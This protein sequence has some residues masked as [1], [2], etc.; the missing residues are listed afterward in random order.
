MSFVFDLPALYVLGAALCFIG[1]KYELERL[2]KIT[3]GILIALTFILFSALLY[4]DIFR[5]PMCNIFEIY[6]TPIIPDMKGSEFIINWPVYPILF[7]N[8]NNS[9]Y[10]SKDNFPLFFAIVL[11]LLYPVAIFLGYATALSYS[12]KQ[13]RKLL[14]GSRSYEDVKSRTRVAK[15]PRFSVA[16]YPDGQRGINNLKEAVEAAIEGLGGM[17]PNF[18]QKGDTVLIKANICGGNPD[19]SATYTSQEVVGY[20]VDMVR[21]AGGKPFVCD[22]DMVW[23]K[24]WVQVK[25]EGWDKWAKKNNV[26]LVNLTETN[27]VYFDFGEG[28][29]FS[30]NEKP[31]QEIVSARVLDADVIINIPKMKTHFGADVTLGMKNMYGTLPEEDKAFYHQKGGVEELLYWVNH[32]F[33]PTLTI[34][35]GSEGGEAEGPLAAHSVQ[36]NTII[37]SNN[38]V[39]ADAIAAKLMGFEHPFADLKFLR[40]VKEH[41]GDANGLLSVIPKEMNY[42]AAQLIN[43]LDLPMNSKDGKWQLPIPEVAEETWSFMENLLGFPGMAT[44]FSIGADFILLDAARLPYWKIL[45]TALMEILFSP[46]FWIRKTKDSA[47]DVSRRRINLGIFVFIALVSLYFFA[48]YLPRHDDN[49]LSDFNRSLE[50]FLGFAFALILGA[51]FSRMMQTKHLVAITLSSIGVSYFVESFAPWA[52]WW[53]YLRE[54]KELSNGW[55]GLPL[56]PYYPLLAVPIFIISI[57]GLTYV[58]TPV[59]SS[60]KGRRFRLVPYAVIMTAL[61][62]FLY[63][64]GYLAPNY[65]ALKDPTRN[66]ILIYAV[67][68]ILGLY[69]NEKEGLNWNIA[70]VMVAV[71]LGFFTEY[72][73]A[74][75]GYWAYPH[76]DLPAFIG[77][78]FGGST[79]SIN[80]NLSDYID[81]MQKEGFARLPI[82]VSLSWALNTWAAC[83]LALIFGIDMSKAFV[84][85]E[86]FDCKDPRAVV[87]KGESLAEEGEYDAAIEQYEKAIYLLTCKGQD[88]N[89]GS[90]LQEIE[91]LSVEDPLAL[92]KAWYGKGTALAS[93]G[94]FANSVMAYDKAIEQYRDIYPAL[95]GIQMTEALYHKAAAK[96]N[97]AMQGFDIPE[98]NIEAE[99]EKELRNEDEKEKKEES[100]EIGEDKVMLAKE[101]LSSYDEALNACLQALNSSP[102]APGMYINILLDK[103]LTLQQLG[104]SDECFADYDKSLA[105]FKNYSSMEAKLCVYKGLA[106]IYWADVNLERELYKEAIDC[107]DKAMEL[108]SQLKVADKACIASARWGKGYAKSKQTYLKNPDDF[109]ESILEDYH[110]SLIELDTKN[111][112][113]IWSDLGDAYMDQ[114]KYQDA[115]N[116]YEKALELHSESTDLQNANLWR[117]KGDAIWKLAAHIWMG[118][119]DAHSKISESQKDISDRLK[120]E[121]E[122]FKAYKRSIEVLDR[123]PRDSDALAGKGFVLFKM[124]RYREAL[125]AYEKAVLISEPKGAGPALMP[126]I[127]SLSSAKACTGKGNVLFSMGRDIDARL[128]FDKSKKMVKDYSPALYSSAMLS[129]SEYQRQE[130][131]ASKADE[132]EKA[133]IIDPRY[134]EVWRHR[135]TY[136]SMLGL[137]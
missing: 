84:N 24:F 17:S 12:K 70:M 61:F 49:W 42:T 116:A 40:F 38:V 109:E 28:T 45:Q 91:S 43:V 30:C 77:M 21:E 58:L 90:G 11:F 53:V 25:A 16:R 32:A 129:G 121:D 95:S 126:L 73:G 56:P 34:I 64:E 67:L 123:F 119:G 104:R 136:L 41:M 65:D 69:F 113:F 78:A 80:L 86:I 87:R 89:E 72:F 82:F 46:R 96:Q 83:G 20:V 75:S 26:E 10:I 114:I 5:F 60:L 52:G 29:L 9:N 6:N 102:Q 62:L 39:W 105:L 106:L 50:Y 14:L 27:L 100:S 120:D 111:V 92:G 63:L 88:E 55:F 98:K 122:A 18:V 13:S 22:A 19:I 124:C 3:V 2:T 47:L 99:D 7:N 115:L 134:A 118:K 51:F 135:G 23:A 68:A 54:S 94:D 36:F 79:S 66:M 133:R 97:L 15:E 108:C 85:D 103:T 74:L 8:S 93:L 31:N 1:K 112:S 57:I 71:G 33:T 107:F 35:D 128:A 101:A 37:A 137:E 125:L 81:L 59:L 132:I 131:A 117:G 110:K 4:A 127:S 76:N 130:K 44:L 48:G